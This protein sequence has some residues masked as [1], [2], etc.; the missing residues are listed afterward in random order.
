MDEVC[1]KVLHGIRSTRWHIDDRRRDRLFA[2]N[3]Y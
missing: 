2:T 3:D 1:L